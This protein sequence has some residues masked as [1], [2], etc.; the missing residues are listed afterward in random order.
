MECLAKE[1]AIFS[2]GIKVLLL[3][4]GYFRTS[5]FS[6]INHVAE[7]VE[8][9]AQFNAGTYNIFYRHTSATHLAELF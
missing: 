5:A 9:Y 7:R 1:L 2:P 4:P 3:E 8:L 6:N